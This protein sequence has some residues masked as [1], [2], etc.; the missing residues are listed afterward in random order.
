MLKQ[1]SDFFFWK[2]VISKYR[3]SKL[4]TLLFYTS[5]PGPNL[6][7]SLILS[8]SSCNNAPGTLV[9]ENNFL[10]GYSGGPIQ[11]T[12]SPKGNTFAQGSENLG[13]TAVFRSS[14]LLLAFKMKG[15]FQS[16]L[17]V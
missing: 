4:F 1:I 8:D 17:Y 14:L 10:L 9:P 7:I 16:L 6:T 13:K 15:A 5:N 11:S 3:N 2:R 12:I